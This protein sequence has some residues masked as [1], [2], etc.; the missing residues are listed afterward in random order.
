M[1][2]RLGCDVDADVTTPGFEKPSED[3]TGRA[4]AHRATIKSRHGQDAVGRARQENLVGRSKVCGRKRTLVP[5]NP[6]ACG[7]LASEGL[8]HARKGIAAR[9]RDQV[10]EVTMT[11]LAAEVSLMRPSWWASTARAPA[12]AAAAS[13]SARK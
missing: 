9:W 10:P 2:P 7:K 1:V 12:S 4:C 11:T 6:E 13:R 8:T 3:G 5:G